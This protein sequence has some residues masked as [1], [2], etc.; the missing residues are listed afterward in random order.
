MTIP[1]NINSIVAI[2]TKMGQKV[3]LSHV[4]FMSFLLFWLDSLL[5]FLKQ[6]RSN[7]IISP[8]TE[9]SEIFLYVDPFQNLIK[10]MKLL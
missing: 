8:L 4:Y 7:T 3:F 10:A 5:Y 9:G 1:R 2:Q 6:G